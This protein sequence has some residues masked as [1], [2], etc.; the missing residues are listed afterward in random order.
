MV[1]EDADGAI[2]AHLHWMGNVSV[3]LVEMEFQELLPKDW[4]RW[5]ERSAGSLVQEAGRVV[6]ASPWSSVCMR[7]HCSEIAA[8]LCFDI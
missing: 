8:G 5:Q 6:Q 7:G 2:A 1:G 4:L 3:L